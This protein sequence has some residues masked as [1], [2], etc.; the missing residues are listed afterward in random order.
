MFLNMPEDIA[1]LSSL[2]LTSA[3]HIDPSGKH[4]RPVDVKGTHV[5]S[6]D[7]IACMLPIPA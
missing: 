7:N 4:I 5:F 6:L 2:Y 3:K 1:P